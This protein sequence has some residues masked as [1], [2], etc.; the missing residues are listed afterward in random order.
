M[1]VLTANIHMYLNGQSLLL[2]QLI[3]QKIK[4]NKFYKGTFTLM[5]KCMSDIQKRCYINVPWF[6]I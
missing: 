3:K 4:I 1:L 6:S 2:E 5:Y